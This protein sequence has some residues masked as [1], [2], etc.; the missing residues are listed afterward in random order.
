MSHRGL[1]IASAAFA[2]GAC[3]SGPHPALQLA[4]TDLSCEQSQLTL[5]QIYPKKVRIEGCGKTAIYV[6]ACNGYGSDETC[7]WGRQYANGFERDAAEHEKAERK[8]AE[9]ERA[10]VESKS[11]EQEKADHAKADE[12]EDKSGDPPEVAPK[13]SDNE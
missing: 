6:D 13:A 3:A 11:A 4:S 8:R 1:F 7:G 5:H 10:A 2:F 9:A 12:A